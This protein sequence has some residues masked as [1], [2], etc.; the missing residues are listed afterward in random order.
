MAFQMIRRSARFDVDWPEDFVA[1]RLVE[2]G[3]QDVGEFYHSGG[4]HADQM[5]IHHIRHLDVANLL[6]DTVRRRITQIC[7]HCTELPT[8]V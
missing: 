5:H 1:E 4:S 3:K 8:T 6:I 7:D 2:S